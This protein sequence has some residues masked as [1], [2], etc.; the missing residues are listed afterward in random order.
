MYNIVKALNWLR[1]SQLGEHLEALLGL[2]NYNSGSSA[3][4]FYEESKNGLLI[5][6]ICG[7]SLFNEGLNQRIMKRPVMQPSP[8]ESPPL[9]TDSPARKKKKH[10]GITSL[11]RN[12]VCVLNEM[13]PG[14]E[15]KLV[16][17][18]GP[19]H[20]PIFTMSVKMDGQEV[21][22]QGRTK[23]HAKQAAAE[24]ALRTIIQL[25]EM[26]VMTLLNPQLQSAN[27]DF[28][29]DSMEYDGSENKDAAM[30]EA[31]TNASPGLKVLSR[32]MLGVEKSPVMI[33]NEMRPGLKYECTSSSGESYAKFTMSVCIDSKTFEGTV[34]KNENPRTLKLHLTR[35][36]LENPFYSVNEFLNWQHFHH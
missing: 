34:V 14:L 20:C 9:E 19:V 8:S 32:H 2:W 30:L 25:P 21:M 3:F 23:K 15:Y 29:S 16:S 7:E 10:S 1:D 12:A 27:V 22:G 4:S 33:L 28:T 5:C 35:W 31:K 6:A 24:A 36:L 17:Q 13:R 18:T 11:P 26:H